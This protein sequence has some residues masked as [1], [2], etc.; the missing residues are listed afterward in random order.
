MLKSP[1]MSVEVWEKKGREGN[2]LKNEEKIKK[3]RQ[4]K[5]KNVKIDYDE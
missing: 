3:K 1:P 5:L 2:D 4:L